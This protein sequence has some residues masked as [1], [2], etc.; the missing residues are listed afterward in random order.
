MD[1]FKYAL[2]DFVGDFSQ[3][4]LWRSSD[5]LI[6][7]VEITGVPRTEWVMPDHN[8]RNSMPN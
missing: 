7:Q 5:L 8:T 3:T 1:V 6:Q 2:Q 4:A